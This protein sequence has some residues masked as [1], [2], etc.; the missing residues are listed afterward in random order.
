MEFKQESLVDFVVNNYP[1]DYGCE[2]E[3]LID[4]LNKRKSISNSTTVALHRAT[5]QMN[6]DSRQKD[7]TFLCARAKPFRGVYPQMYVFCANFMNPKIQVVKESD[8]RIL[9]EN[10]E[11]Y[12][13]DVSPELEKVWEY[14][15]DLASLYSLWDCAR[16]GIPYSGIVIK[17]KHITTFVTPG[18][19]IL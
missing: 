11:I 18:R 16:Q 1:K 15:N 3:R 17:Q 14:S 9:L 7:W 5:E 4:N 12:V 8:L 6:F 19:H 10:A 2:V 13:A